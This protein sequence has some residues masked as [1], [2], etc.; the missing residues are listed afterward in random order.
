MKILILLML[1]SFSAL[2]DTVTKT[3]SGQMRY[4]DQ[5]GICS[6][7]HFYLYAYQNVSLNQDGSFRRLRYR[8]RTRSILGDASDYVPRTMAEGEYVIY[9]G[10]IFSVAV[11]WV[12]GLPL[13]YFQPNF[14]VNEWQELCR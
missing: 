11:P 4:C 7:E 8:L 3:C 5:Y 6:M 2:A 13:Y 14:G 1:F 10:P 12:S 9:D